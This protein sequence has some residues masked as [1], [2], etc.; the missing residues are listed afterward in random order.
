MRY[1]IFKCQSNS[2]ENPEVIG[3]GL[4]GYE[5][6]AILIRLLVFLKATDVI[7]IKGFGE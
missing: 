3:E 6:I 1:S 7:I 5:C 4:Y 2:P